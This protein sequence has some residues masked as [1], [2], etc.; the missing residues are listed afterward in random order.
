MWCNAFDLVLAVTFYL[1]VA[2][3]K[4]NYPVKITTRHNVNFL[5]RISASL[6][7]CIYLT[8]EY[9]H[10]QCWKLFLEA[11]LGVSRGSNVMESYFL[12]YLL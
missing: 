7:N 4:Y 11:L 5:Q 6:K 3:S 8:H 9:A 10:S 12:K 1:S 2:V